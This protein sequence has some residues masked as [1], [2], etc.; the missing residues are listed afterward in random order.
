LNCKGLISELVDYLDEALDASSRADL[1][2]HLGKCK[3]CRIVVD[4]TRKT[5]DIFCN[6]EPAPLPEDVRNRL[7]EALAK[8]LHRRAN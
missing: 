6:A 1:E 5:I 2:Q 4:T 8:R 7:H 3:N